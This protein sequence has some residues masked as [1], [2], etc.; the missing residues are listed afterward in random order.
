MTG[1]L[2]TATCSDQCSRAR[3]YRF[4]ISSRRRLD[5]RPSAADRL[6]DRHVIPLQFM[7]VDDALCAVRREACAH[8]S[9][10]ASPLRRQTTPTIVG[11][12]RTRG[13][14]RSRSTS[15]I[16]RTLAAT[17]RDMSGR[18]QIGR[19]LLER[20]AQPSIDR[21]G[22]PRL[23]PIDDRPAHAMLARS[24]V[25]SR[26]SSRDVVWS[27]GVMRSSRLAGSPASNIG[28]L[29]PAGARSACAPRSTRSGSFQAE[30]SDGYISPR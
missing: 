26:S 28:R 20:S 9:D 16:P 4:L 30:S 24:I 23:R 7:F 11:P 27:E 13:Q 22:E 1:V 8:A 21:L 15:R 3:L 19:L 18:Q 5:P 2:W 25:T 12:D 6:T 17:I 10:I 29:P 14:R